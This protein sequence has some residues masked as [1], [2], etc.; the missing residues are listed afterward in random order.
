MI[1]DGFISKRY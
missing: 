1:K